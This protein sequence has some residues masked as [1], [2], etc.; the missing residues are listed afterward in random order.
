MRIYWEN[1]NKINKY[2][3]NKQINKM[4]KNLNCFFYSILF[5]SSSLLIMLAMMIILRLLFC[6]NE[7][8]IYIIKLLRWVSSLLIYFIIICMFSPLIKS[9]IELHNNIKMHK[10]QSWFN[11]INIVLHI[12][13][14]EFCLFVWI[15]VCLYKWKKYEIVIII[16]LNKEKCYKIESENWIV[17]CCLL[18]F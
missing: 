13:F 7:I 1:N 12:R 16:N 8:K 11:S 5:I 10:N 2:N 3:L 4:N 6:F 15:Y 17:F 14:F 9:P 18:L